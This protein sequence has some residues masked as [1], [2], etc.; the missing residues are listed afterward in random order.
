MNDNLDN[1][2]YDPED[3]DIDF[4]SD[5]EREKIKY[6]SMHNTYKLILNEY[7]FEVFPER[8]FWLLTDYDSFS[9]FDV[10]IKYFQH[11]DREDYEKC[12]E[13]KRIKEARLKIR[14]KRVAKKGKFT[15]NLGADD[16]PE[17]K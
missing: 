9:V 1:F 13:L 2:F 8:L 17:L 14:S 7:D 12:A 10:L 3:D 5:E 6:H 4:L 16:A 15:Y 11:P